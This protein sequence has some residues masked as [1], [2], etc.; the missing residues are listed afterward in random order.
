MASHRTLAP[1]RQLAHSPH[2]R[3]DITTTGSPGSKPVTPTPIRSTTPASSW[4]MMAPA[5][6]L[7]LAEVAACK[8]D[9]Q[10]PQ[11]LTRTISSPDSATGSG[12]S[13][14]SS[15]APIALNTHAFIAGDEEDT[16]FLR[17]GKTGGRFSFTAATPSTTSA[18]KKPSISKA[19]D[20]SKCGP[21]V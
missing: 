15:G 19:S 4:P 10:M 5:G 13:T 1:A 14:T 12:N 17:C 20:A 7:A 21:K 16:Y 11:A 6:S 9:P 18:L 8:S 2:A 3:Y